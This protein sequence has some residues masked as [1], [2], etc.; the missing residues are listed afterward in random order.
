M[1]WMGQGNGALV[2][3]NRHTGLRAFGM[4]GSYEEEVAKYEQDLKTWEGEDR[5]IDLDYSSGVIGKQEYDDTKRIHNGAKPVYPSKPSNVPDAAT[6]I[7]GAGTT[8]AGSLANM[9]LA[10][11][12]AKNQLTT[13]RSGTDSGGIMQTGG[14]PW[15]SA[16]AAAKKYAWV[17]IPIALLIG[18]YF[19]LGRTRKNP[20][21]RKEY[22]RPDRIRRILLKSGS[23][24]IK[25]RKAK[26]W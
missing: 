9:Y 23:R 20:S 14:S 12:N 13:L 25:S 2:Y 10:S 18:A 3:G 4:F 5:I 15:V 22:E 21:E 1:A 7:A 26:M 16:G 24:H 17:G 19:F 6:V 11:L 8:V